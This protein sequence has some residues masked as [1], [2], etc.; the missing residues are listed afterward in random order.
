MRCERQWKCACSVWP[1]AAVC[2]PPHR[3]PLR[4]WTGTRASRSS[5][6][7]SACSEVDSAARQGLRCTQGEE[8][9]GGGLVQTWQTG[10]RVLKKG[11]LKSSRFAEKLERFFRCDFPDATKQVVRDSQ[12]ADT[13]AARGRGGATCAHRQIW[14]ARKWQR[15]FTPTP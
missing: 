10:R 11:N 5:R 7:T 12:I 4:C 13:A 2:P 14:W 9:S 3:S 1:S 8:E 15:H 6:L